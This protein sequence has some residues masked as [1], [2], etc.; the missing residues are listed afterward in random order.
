MFQRTPSCGVHVIGISTEA[1]CNSLGIYN[2]GR[3]SVSPRPLPRRRRQS[4]FI[5][6]T[7]DILGHSCTAYTSH[8]VGDLHFPCTRRTTLT[9]LCSMSYTVRV[10]VRH[11]K[12]DAYFHIAEMAVWHYANGGAWA[13]S[14]G[15][16]VLTVSNSRNL[17]LSLSLFRFCQLPD[18]KLSVLGQGSVEPS[19]LL[20]NCA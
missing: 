8:Q 7:R 5:N 12:P 3:Q 18:Y 1:L 9:S 13:N 16:L 14:D 17:F 2:E 15:A 4:R 11:N 10:R 19:E 20:T 6:S